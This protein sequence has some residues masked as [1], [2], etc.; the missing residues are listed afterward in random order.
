MKKALLSAMIF[1]IT[2]AL[3]AQA[4][5]SNFSVDPR[6]GFTSSAS[7]QSTMFTMGN[8]SD[9]I[10]AK[11]IVDLS[12]AFFATGYSSEGGIGYNSNM[13][14]TW[15]TPIFSD[16]A[17]GIIGDYQLSTSQDES[18]ID[19]IAGIT[20]TTL[21]DTS[22]LNMRMAYKI[23]E[24]GLHYRF[25]RTFGT[26]ENMSASDVQWEHEIG[27]SH[28]IPGF[29]QFYSPIG[30]IIDRSIDSV[31]T[32]SDDTTG[33]ETIITEQNNVVSFYM[34]PQVEF[35]VSFGPITTLRTGIN[36][37]VDI[38]D[39]S[40]AKETS[41]TISSSGITDSVTT[42]Y[43]ERENFTVGIDAGATLMWVKE[44]IL[45]L[46]E[47]YCGFDYAWRKEVAVASVENDVTSYPNST[48]TIASPDAYIGLNAGILID[49]TEW[50]DF[51]AGISYTVNWD[52]TIT[53]SS[54]A[55]EYDYILSSAF[56]SAFGIGFT[57]A[58]DFILDI[59][60]ETPANLLDLPSL[61]VSAMYR[62]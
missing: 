40:N 45:V 20:T 2:A 28:R 60:I 62:F 12:R 19:A 58:K 15:A 33:N 35:P 9:S 52:N 13:Q 38:Y 47:P 30:F 42:T 50:F 59:N 56:M 39:L 10:H 36:L 61:G 14:V 44:R 18:I 43:K 1:F 41:T 17:I 53:T 29:I 27:I 16:M 37:G 26:A 32:Y 49:I 6:T 11:G 4:T 3:F 31:A 54:S 48:L 25:A 51:R 23:E 57:L 21:F 46:A 55:K 22:S 7:R 34:F 24:T 8:E 5:Q